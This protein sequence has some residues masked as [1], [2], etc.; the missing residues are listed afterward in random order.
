MIHPRCMIHPGCTRLRDAFRPVIRRVPQGDH[1]RRLARRWHT[2]PLLART[3]E[4]FETAVSRPEKAS[5][6]AGIDRHK[7]LQKRDLRPNDLGAPQIPQEP[8]FG[9]I[10]NLGKWHKRPRK[11][12]TLCHFSGAGKWEPARRTEVHENATNEPIVG[13]SSVVIGAL[14]IVSCNREVVDEANAPREPTRDSSLDAWLRTVWSSKPRE[15]AQPVAYPRRP[16]HNEHIL[17]ILVMSIMRVARL[18]E[19]HQGCPAAAGLSF[20]VPRPGRRE[21]GARSLV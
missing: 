3:D 13:P 5:K 19:P 4:Q 1:S 9:S 7:F 21:C 17:P 2:T 12:A 20:V 15:S 14:P 8:C 16:A 6:S 11:A 10:P 18:A